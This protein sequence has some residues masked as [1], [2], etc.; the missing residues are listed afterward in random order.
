MRQRAKG[1]ANIFFVNCTIRLLSL[2]TSI[3]IQPGSMRRIKRQLDR[4]IAPGMI[5]GLMILVTAE[6]NCQE[7]IDSLMPVRGF[8]IAA[9][10]VADLE[11]FI[12]FIKEELAPRKVNTL[13]LRVDFNFRFESHPELRDSNALSKG[14][15]GKIVKVCRD[16]GIKIIPQINLLGHQSWA[17]RTGNLLRVYP[18][19]DETPKV[20]MPEKYV[21]PNPDKLYCKS[22]CP[23][24]PGVHDIVFDLV[25]EIC[26]IFE[27]EAF[28][29][30]M[31]EVFYIG[32]DQCPRCSGRDK[33]ELFAGE[34]TLIRNHLSLKNRRLWIWGDRLIDGKTTGMGEWEAS[35]NNT[36]RAIDLIPKDVMICDWHY[37][38]PHQSAVYFAMKGFSVVTCPKDNLVSAV[39]QV[40]DM[41]RFR[42]SSSKAMSGRFSGIVQTVWSGAAPFMDS[43]YGR[44]PGTGENATVS[45]FKAVFN[46]INRLEK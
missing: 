36:Y 14:D 4:M 30:G 32:E 43:Y 40:N 18:Q 16:A 27:A 1:W 10:R 24:H 15:V 6:G 33:A 46:E 42:S 31:D 45:C 12:T 39:A 2:C 5:I 7:K 26:D 17:G 11:G 41:I 29:A 44:K 35:L 22:Y 37:E 9:P 34:V 23:L 20:K 3:N 28:H 8:C 38:K 19:F 13:I 21:W 25:D